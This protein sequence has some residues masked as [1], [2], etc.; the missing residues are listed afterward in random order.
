VIAG[1]RCESGEPVASKHIGNVNLSLDFLAKLFNGYVHKRGNG[2]GIREVRIEAR[3]QRVERSLRWPETDG[4][5]L[6]AP[7]GT[8]A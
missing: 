8:L 5:R 6:D 4:T 3:D 7:I 2:Y 1:R